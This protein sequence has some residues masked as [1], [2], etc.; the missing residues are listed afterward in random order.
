MSE[1]FSATIFKVGINP[2]VDV[3]ARV[4]KTLGRTGYIPIQGTLNGHAFRAGLV[5]LGGGRHRLFINGEMRRAAGVDVDDRVTVALEYDGKP[6]KIT[7]PH[8]LARALKDSRA[9]KR[10]WDNLTPS[11]RKEI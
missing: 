5:S 4:S 8:Q 9:A 3:P 10:T 11:R 1:R 2:C 7:V 6:R